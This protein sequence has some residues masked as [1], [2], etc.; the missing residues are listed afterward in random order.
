MAMNLLNT[1]QRYGW[2]SI[3]LH[4]LMLLVLIGVYGCMALTEFYD[5]NNSNWL[6]LRRWHF[7]LGLTVLLLVGIRLVAKWV[8]PAPQIAPPISRWQN[9]LSKS[10]QALLYMLM[11]AMPLAGWLM[12]SA[13]GKPPIFFGFQLPALLTEN[14]S[15]AEAIKEAHET[16]AALIMLL[17]GLHAIA[18]LY[19]HYF[20]RDNTL[21]RILPMPL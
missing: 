14:K 2:I 12:L 11:I 4:W 16:G 19:H 20:L 17:V 9:I 5:E 1:Q 3:G 21:R 13:Y 7:N 15:L 18:A 10:V 6:L 8:A